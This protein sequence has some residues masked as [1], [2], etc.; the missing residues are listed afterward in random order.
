MRRIFENLLEA[1]TK[2]P[3]LS[4]LTVIDGWTLE[5]NLRGMPN[6]LTT[7]PNLI[8]LMHKA[9]GFQL[10]LGVS[11]DMMEC[12]VKLHEL[13][14]EK[15]GK[16]IRDLPPEGQ[17]L[18]QSKEVPT[19]E[20]STHSGLVCVDNGPHYSQKK[21]YRV[22]VQSGDVVQPLQLDLQLL[23]N[24]LSQQISAVCDTLRE[25][26]LQGPKH[27][28]YFTEM[29]FLELDFGDIRNRVVMWTPEPGESRYHHM[30]ETVNMLAQA[31]NIPE[32]FCVM[33]RDVI[34]T[35]RREVDHLKNKLINVDENTRIARLWKSLISAQ[36]SVEILDAYHEIL[37]STGFVN[38]DLHKLMNQVEKDFEATYPYKKPPDYIQAALTAVNAP[39]SQK[40]EPPVDAVS[41]A[42]QVQKLARMG[43]VTRPA[44]P[45][46]ALTKQKT[47]I[48]PT[49]VGSDLRADSEN[50]SQLDLALLE[51]QRDFMETHP[52]TVTFIGHHSM[53]NDVKVTRLYGDLIVGATMKSLSVSRRN[54]I[55]TLFARTDFAGMSWS[56]QAPRSKHRVFNEAVFDIHIA[57]SHCSSPEQYRALGTILKMIFPAGLPGQDA[58]IDQAIQNYE[59]M[60]R[61][62][63]E[64]TDDAVSQIKNNDPNDLVHMRQAF[65]MICAL[66]EDAIDCIGK[67]TSAFL[68]HYQSQRDCEMFEK[69]LQFKRSWS[70]Q[71]VALY[72]RA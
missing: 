57:I 4:S 20:N 9:S 72:A 37:C 17:H 15:V 65:N 61:Y 42:L 26:V 58:F 5:R 43:Y 45:R 34:L 29:S 39:L 66:P 59:S 44:L 1:M 14:D 47:M 24:H 31:F 11:H 36:T 68:S 52:E 16:I 70:P 21:Y 27:G 8:V 18:T 60:S 32:A 40:K 38:P 62:V 2:D 33:L 3:R 23:F 51:G 55:H 10:K 63:V 19:I 12:Y 22:N 41:A 54:E 64:H 7:G 46:P 53:V 28:F 48:P 35:A 49:K 69:I 6:F 50:A 13:A 25:S 71:Y 67:L 56:I 30:L